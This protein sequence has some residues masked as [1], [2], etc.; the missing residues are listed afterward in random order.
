MSQLLLKFLDLIGRAKLD[1]S[2]SVL[3]LMVRH[4]TRESGSLIHAIDSEG[5]AEWREF[6]DPQKLFEV[7]GPDPSGPW[8]YYHAVPLFASLS[9]P[10]LFSDSLSA[11]E[12][13]LSPTDPSTLAMVSEQF[14][15][16]DDGLLGE[17]WGEEWLSQ[18]LMVIVELPGVQSVTAALRFIS[19][20]F[21][22]V[23]TFDNWP[24]PAG[25]LRPEFILR[26]LLR[27]APLMKLLREGLSASSP[28]VLIAD[29]ERLGYSMPKVNDFDN[30]YFLDDSILPSVEILRRE[31]I[32][33]IVCLL[34][35]ELAVPSLDLCSYF[36][37]LKTANFQ[38]VYRCDVTD[39][40]LTPR[41][42]LTTEISEQ[43]SPSKFDFSPSAAGGFGRLI[44]EP[45]SGGG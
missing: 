33:G 15:A 40:S 44:P 21:Q 42:F 29:N 16:L 9:S 43:F 32:S 6:L 38:P 4:R 37:S 20:G 30:R 11:K 41:P 5:G 14:P 7:W 22:P 10:D 35:D 19:A 34:S 8:A 31:K 25:H 39:P 28:P 45:S 13:V 24:N 17:R 26:Q 18:R 12:G 27:Y 1:L 36:R 23:C 3:E 2:G